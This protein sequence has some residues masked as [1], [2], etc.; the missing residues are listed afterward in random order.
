MLKTSRPASPA[1]A[2]GQSVLPFPG[3]PTSKIPFE[4]CSKARELSGVFRNS[5]TSR[6]SS[7][8]SSKPATSEKV[9]F[10]SFSA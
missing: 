10:V 4:S 8:A 3:G 7:F 9:H 1:T 6:S 2:R 5:I